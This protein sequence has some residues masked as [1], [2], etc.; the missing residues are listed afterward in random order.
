MS[1]SQDILDRLQAND[2]SLTYLDLS[3]QN[4]SDDDIIQLCEAIVSNDKLTSLD[5]SENNIGD[6][7]ADYLSKMMNLTS[8]SV[9]DNRIGDIGAASL[10]MM[11]NLISLDVNFNHIRYPGATSLAGM[12]YLTHLSYTE[13]LLIPS[14]K[15]SLQETRIENRRNNVRELFAAIPVCALF[16]LETHLTALI[17]E[18]LPHGMT[19]GQKIIKNTEHINLAPKI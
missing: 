4:L 2:P 9:S 18:Y 19:I 1:I 12:K 5:V 13:N 8:L 7:G 6:K 14:A 10:S 3:N 17:L 15:T 16:K 11:S